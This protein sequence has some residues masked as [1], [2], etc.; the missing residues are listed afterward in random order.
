MQWIM[1]TFHKN[2]KIY[3]FKLRF[4]PESSAVPCFHDDLRLSVYDIVLNDSHLLCLQ[5]EVP[6]ELPV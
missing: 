6:E 1:Y 4:L 2:L 5:A 3:F